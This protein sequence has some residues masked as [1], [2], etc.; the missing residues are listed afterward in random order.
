M[1]IS[2]KQELAFWVQKFAAA[3]V[4][5]CRQTSKRRTPQEIQANEIH[6]QAA[7]EARN[8]IQ[9][10]LFLGYFDKRLLDACDVAPSREQILTG[11]Q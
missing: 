7:T 6:V 11:G 10:A 2:E 4:Y 3:Y 8:K 9:N 1:E 5:I